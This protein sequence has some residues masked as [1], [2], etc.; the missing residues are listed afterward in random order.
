MHISFKKASEILTKALYQMPIGTDASGGGGR[1]ELWDG[2][3]TP[4]VKICGSGS[5]MMSSRPQ[6]N[7]VHLFHAFFHAKHG[8]WSTL[9]QWTVLALRLSFVTPQFP[10]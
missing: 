6:N 8:C 1:M 4:G 7:W 5:A 2:L 9:F 10:V 3:Q